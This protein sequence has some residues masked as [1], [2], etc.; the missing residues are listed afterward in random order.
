MECV[1][2]DIVK[3]KWSEEGW[4]QM[5]TTEEDGALQEGV[6]MFASQVYATKQLGEVT[7][8]FTPGTAFVFVSD[9]GEEDE[10]IW[11]AMELG[12]VIK[13]HFGDTFPVQYEEYYPI[14]DT[15]EEEC[16]DEALEMF[17]LVPFKSDIEQ[18]LADIAPY[19]Y[20]YE[21]DWENEMLQQM[22]QRG[23]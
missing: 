14:I 9:L 5:P 18:R 23:I 3:M 17:D 1:V 4:M 13:D 7:V 10:H 12:R 19:G 11:T 22:L 20:E 8:F 16:M 21:C 2:N 15:G 6:F